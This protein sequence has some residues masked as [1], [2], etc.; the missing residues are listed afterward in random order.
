[1]SAAVNRAF[2]A[3]GENVHASRTCPRRGPSMAA[4]HRGEALRF[5]DRAGAERSCP[6]ATS[7]AK[8]AEY[9][10]Q[11]VKHVKNALLLGMAAD[12]LISRARTG[13]VTEETADDARAYLVAAA[14]RQERSGASY[15]DVN[16]DDIDED[17]GVRCVAMAWL[18]RLLEPELG[19]PLSLD[20]SSAEVLEAGLRASAAASGPLLLNSASVERLEVLDVAAEL[21]AAVV[22]SAVRGGGAAPGIDERLDWAETML[23]AALDR[24]LSPADC[25]VDL[26]VL[27]AGLACDAGTTF[28][29][30][31][32]AFR[33]SH[34]P[35]VHI[36]GGLSNI[37]FGLP[38]RRVLN[39]AFVAMAID[40]GV[41]SGIL[42]PIAVR[43]DRIAG[44]DRSS[45]AFR[46]AAD[47]ILGNDEYAARYL[48]AYRAGALT[49]S[50]VGALAP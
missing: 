11:R 28:L 43:L 34:D 42:D 39:D 12:G 24:G 18:V 16:V 41:D 44:M 5:V 48:A 25:H 26:L 10:R 46:L 32:R 19:I 45:E 17:A 30:S 27:P 49:G 13:E 1:V 4:T 29:T 3:I 7:I 50:A 35:A 31:S 22:L 15:I 14:V 2:V 47:V 40:A 37:S 36:T 33:A 9:A 38:A 8:S 6:I 20:S 23:R 21:R